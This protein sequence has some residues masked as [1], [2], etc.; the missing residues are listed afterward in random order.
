MHAHKDTTEGGDAELEWRRQRRDADGLVRKALG[1]TLPRTSEPVPELLTLFGD[2]RDKQLVDALGAVISIVRRQMRNEFGERLADLQPQLQKISSHELEIAKLSGGID[3]LCCAARRGTTAAGE[4]SARESLDGGHCLPRW[5][6]RRLRRCHVSSKVRHRARAGLAR[7]DVPRRGGQR[8]TVRGT[9]SGNVEY[10][11]FDVAMVNGSSFVAL[12][13]NPGA[14][15][16]DDWHLLASRGSRG[17]RGERGPVGLGGVKGER[18]E[19]APTIRSWE[20]DRALHCDAGDE[21]RLAR[22]APRIARVV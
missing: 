15:P 12:K 19:A 22:S 10:R 2:H 18:G 13:N 1:D 6:R 7:L 20:L 16:G 4:V 21:R 17:S 9:Y 5:R 14:C 3:V 11:C 8:F